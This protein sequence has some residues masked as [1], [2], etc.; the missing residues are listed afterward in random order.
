MISSLINFDETRSY[1]VVK[2][3]DAI[4]DDKIDHPLLDGPILYKYTTLNMLTDTLSNH[5]LNI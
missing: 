5:M 1:R 2:D 3:C 4:I